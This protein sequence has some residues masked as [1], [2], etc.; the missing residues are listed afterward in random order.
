MSL[1]TLLDGDARTALASLPDES[2]QCCITSPPY[3]WVRKYSDDPN[4]IGAEPTLELYIEHLVEVF[5]EVRRVLKPTGLLWVVIADTYARRA[6]GQHDEN[7]KIGR[8][9]TL[10]TNSRSG[11]H[12]YRKIESA[13][14]RQRKM[15][16]GC[17]QGDLI[18]VPWELAFA[19]RRDGWWWRQDVVWEKPD[20][21]PEPV[22]SRFVR[23]HEEVL[24]F[25][26]GE[27][28]QVMERSHERVLMFSQAERR[29]DFDHEAVKEV[30]VSNHA[31]GNGYKRGSRVVKAN[32]DGTPRGNDV[33][34]TP[35]KANGLRNR[36]SVLKVANARRRGTQTATYP[37][38]LVEPM[39]EAS[40][41]FGDLVL[42]P[43]TGSGTTGEVALS[44]GRRFVGVELVPDNA[45][46]AR[47]NFLRALSA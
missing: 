5:R 44:L 2:V 15:P 41:R 32:A 39:I 17:K 16:P 23:S 12:S 20:A 28:V 24:L 42:D 35:E 36:R 47:A 21:M 18:G 4:E 14:P 37:H 43:F 46:R 29:Y 8:N 27:G 34:W 3:L 9:N 45:E 40:S 25:D 19:M 22:R 33:G 30:A 31:A 7:L 6:G 1:W 38:A 26:R 13:V 10:H 11:L